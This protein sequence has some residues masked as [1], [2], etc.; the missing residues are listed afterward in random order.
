MRGET[1]GTTTAPGRSRRAEDKRRKTRRKNGKLDMGFTTD[2]TNPTTTVSSPPTSIPFN[3]PDF[4]S[5]VIGRFQNK[6]RKITIS[7]LQKEI[8]TLKDEIKVIKTTIYKLEH[9]TSTTKNDQ[10]N[11][12]FA[13]SSDSDNPDISAQPGLTT[14]L[15][16][17]RSPGHIRQIKTY[18]IQKWYIEI[19]IRISQDYN[20]IVNALV[21]TGAD[22]NCIMEA[23]VPTKY[24]EKSTESLFG[25]NKQ[26]LDI[27]YK[28]ANAKVC[29]RGV[30]Y[31]TDFVMVK[32][33]SQNV[34]IGLPFLHLI[35]PFK[36]IRL[37]DPHM[38][39]KIKQ[40]QAQIE[41]EVCSS[42]PNAFWDWKKHIVS[43]P[44]NTDFS[45][46]GLWPAL[47]VAVPVN[48]AEASVAEAQAFNLT[49][50]TYLKI[51]IPLTYQLT[52]PYLSVIPSHPDPITKTNML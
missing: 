27:Q 12:S 17:P 24:L 3:T 34:I 47:E 38:Q 31:T 36:V 48:E 14:V 10:K 11:P 4:D 6:S 15:N 29:N 21:D 18:K 20:L 25:A 26:Q 37:A 13:S 40:F 5:N 32:T 7:D 49:F 45:E 2:W 8:Q 22:L 44:Y 42:F 33:L 46:K 1:N 51:F 39:E 19:D 41:R 30:C 28:L 43:L 50:Q 52:Y 23:L 35:S 9:S 16:H